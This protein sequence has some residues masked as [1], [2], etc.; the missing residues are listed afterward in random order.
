M[1]F[2]CI[3]VTSIAGDKNPGKLLFTNFEASAFG[4]QQRL[5]VKVKYGKWICLRPQVWG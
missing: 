3:V 5:L 4:C 1:I 2:P